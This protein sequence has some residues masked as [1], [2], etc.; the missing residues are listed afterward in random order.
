[1][2]TVVSD[3]RIAHANDMLYGLAI[4]GITSLGL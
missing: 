1:M 4:M 2:E 3:N